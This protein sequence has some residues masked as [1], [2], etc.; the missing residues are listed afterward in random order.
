MCVARLVADFRESVNQLAEVMSGLERW[1]T[2]YAM[3]RALEVSS[4][5]FAEHEV[6]NAVRGVIDR[7]ELDLDPSEVVKLRQ[8]EILKDVKNSTCKLTNLSQELERITEKHCLE[9]AR[10]P[11]AIGQWLK[12]QGL[13]GRQIGE[14]VKRLNEMWDLNPGMT[15]GDYKQMAAREALALRPGGGQPSC[16]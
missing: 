2:A 13:M 5:T 16:G 10:R 11:P 15:A 4:R 6:E 14:C 1:P 9:I 8:A 12:R 7:L 3:M